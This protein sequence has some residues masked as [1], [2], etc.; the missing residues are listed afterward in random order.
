MSVKG[1]GQTLYIG[2]NGIRIKEFPE[3]DIRFG[4]DGL[5][6]IEYQYADNSRCG[7]LRFKLD[8]GNI[9][10]FCFRR[11]GNEPVSR[12][13]PYIKNYAPGV[14]LEEKDVPF[15]QK[16]VC[17]QIVTHTSFPVYYSLLFSFSCLSFI[18]GPLLR[19]HPDSRRLPPR[20]LSSA[21]RSWRSYV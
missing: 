16:E 12:A 17:A 6:S 8:V 5:V 20:D 1:V 9:H 10:T 7:F 18:S 21:A 15:S 2:R 13:I 19:S 3:K 11:N 4:Y 14:I